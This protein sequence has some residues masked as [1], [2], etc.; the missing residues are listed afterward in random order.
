MDEN[1]FDLFT[2]IEEDAVITKEEEKPEVKEPVVDTEDVLELDK[3]E[4]ETKEEETEE[5]ADPTSVKSMYTVLKEFGA[6]DETDE[7]T[8]EYIREQLQNL[9]EKN[10]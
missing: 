6:V 3:V 9:R 2:D 7:P 4:E 8:E 10:F 1:L 5:V